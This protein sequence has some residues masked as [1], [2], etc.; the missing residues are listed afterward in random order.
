MLGCEVDDLIHWG[1][2]GS[3]NLCLKIN[4][5]KCGIID[6]RDPIPEPDKF[7]V[8]NSNNGL[9]WYW[10]GSNHPYCLCGGF[11]F[12]SSGYISD[13]ESTPQSTLSGAFVVWSKENNE[14]INA[15]IFLDEQERISFTKN[16]LWI[17]R[18]DIEK[19][20][21]TLSNNDL[22]LPNIFNSAEIADKSREREN[23]VPTKHT[24]LSESSLL[25]SLGLMAELLAMSASKY[26]YKNRPNAK[27]IKEAVIELATSTLGEDETKDLQLSNLDKDISLALKLPTD[28]TKG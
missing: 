7:G 8:I 13:L 28:E 19:L 6:K 12:L 27:Q 2:V 23:L 11:W 9:S 21:E 20:N 16:D 3:I 17:T 26:K 25:A 5:M 4:R 1:S 15:T 22:A 18:E 14:V 24:R 10:K